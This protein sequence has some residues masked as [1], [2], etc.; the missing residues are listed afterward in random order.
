MRGDPRRARG[1][2]A[3]HPGGR[4]R[5]GG[6]PR[7]GDDRN[8]GGEQV[9]GR[10]AVRELLRAG[11][12]E[13]GEVLVAAG[14]EPSPLLDEIV[15]LARARGAR[16]RQV[17]ADELAARAVTEA[18]QGVVARARP[19]EA[20]ALDA[21][22][23][24]P[25]GDR[26]PAKRPGAA[27]AATTA[28][29]ATGATGATGASR[30]PAPPFL[31]VLDSV[32]DPRNL[33]S[34]L[35][36]ALSAG[37]TGALIPAHHSARLSPAAT[38]AAA[39]A[40]EHLPIAVVPGVPAA[41]EQLRRAGV[42]SV[43]LDAHGSADI[44]ELTVATEPLALVLGAEGRGLSVLARRRCEVVARIALHGPLESIHVA[45]AAAVACFA[46]AR[47]RAAATATASPAG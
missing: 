35:R 20:V 18:P 21:L 24:L 42:W 47:L 30:P 44:D 27:T 34:V 31:V 2:A 19:V 13:V 45:A 8:L 3:P 26:A 12:R 40:I 38:K 33:G 41:L 46:V 9:E 14:R 28:T 7:S 11:R 39:G 32:T 15:E 23:G 17:G 37:A 1:G 36:T 4:A 16:L 22:I 43:G 5:P 25:S 29:A 10:Q 6:R